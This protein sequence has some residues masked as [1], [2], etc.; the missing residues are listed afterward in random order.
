MAT[1]IMKFINA[2]FGEIRA[3]YIDGE[4]WFVGKDVAQAL[5]YTNTFD[6]LSRHVFDDYKRVLTAK[7]IQQMASQRKGRETRLLEMASQRKG[8]ESPPLDAMYSVRHRQQK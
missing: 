8:G 6:A 5:G 7:I 1:K 4:C 3:R 2:E